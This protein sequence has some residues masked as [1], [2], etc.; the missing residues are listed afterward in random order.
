[1]SVDRGAASSVVF[2]IGKKLTKFATLPTE[3]GSILIEDLR[4]PLRTPP[5][6]SGKETLLMWSSRPSFFSDDP[7]CAQ[8]L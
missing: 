2:P 4:D 3:L 5:P 6:P 8:S 1:M 7:E